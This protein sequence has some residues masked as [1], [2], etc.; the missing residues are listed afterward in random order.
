MLKEQSFNL[1]SSL[2]ITYTI[3]MIY[4]LIVCSK[5][6][7]LLAAIAFI[8]N[9]IIGVFVEMFHPE[10]RQSKS[11]KYSI[12]TSFWLYVILDTLLT[13]IIYAVVST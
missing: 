2:E 3:Y 10:L 7:L 1:M 13:L 11:Q 6:F 4:L 9:V 12:L 8:I 5:I